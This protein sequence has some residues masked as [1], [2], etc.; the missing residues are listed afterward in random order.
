[1]RKDT[2]CNEFSSFFLGALKHNNVESWDPFG[3]FSGPVVECRFG[4]NDEVRSGD[5]LVEFEISDEGDSL[6]SFTETLLYFINTQNGFSLGH[7]FL[8]FHL[9]GYH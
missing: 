9:Q 4:D 7:G 8:P 5:T 2:P 1:M 6:Q 3:N